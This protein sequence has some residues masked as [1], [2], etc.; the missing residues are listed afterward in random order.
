MTRTYPSHG[1]VRYRIVATRGR[2]GIGRHSI[3]DRPGSYRAPM[4]FVIVDLWTSRRVEYHRDLM[5]ALH[6]A[7]EH[8]RDRPP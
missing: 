6:A 5:P 3:A 8:A 7:A 4:R 2:Y 1:P